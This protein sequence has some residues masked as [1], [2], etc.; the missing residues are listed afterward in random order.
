MSSARVVSRT[1]LVAV[2]VAFALGRL[3]TLGLVEPLWETLACA[4]IA[5]L[6]GVLARVHVGRAIARPLHTAANVLDA[7]RHR[8][9]TRR[10][11]P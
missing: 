2:A 5:A 6:V 1:V 9:Y 4:A 10:A 3:S 7:M 11:G 8:D